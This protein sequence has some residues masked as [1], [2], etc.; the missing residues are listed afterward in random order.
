MNWDTKAQQVEVDGIL[1]GRVGR[2]FKPFYHVSIHWFDRLPDET[3]DTGYALRIT[4]MAFGLNVASK[5]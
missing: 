3:K 4:H 1:W 5:Q 2:D